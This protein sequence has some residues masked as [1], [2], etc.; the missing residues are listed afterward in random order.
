MCTPWFQFL[1]RT[2]PTTYFG[3]VICPVIA[4][5]GSEDLQVDTRQ[6]IP[7]ISKAVKVGGNPNA[8]A[9]N[10]LTCFTFF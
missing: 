6:N 2:D 4:L 8:T 9:K 3:K 5:N 10:C 1:Y 7:A